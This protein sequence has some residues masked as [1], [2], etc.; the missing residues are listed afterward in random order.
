[1]SDKME[2]KSINSS[3]G[4]MTKTDVTDS[5]VKALKK[6]KAEITESV[7]KALKSQNKQITPKDITEAVKSALKSNNN[8]S[9]T[10]EEITRSVEKAL[11]NNEKPS[12]W[13]IIKFFATALL[14]IFIGF[15]C[16]L[17]YNWLFVA[18]LDV[19][20]KSITLLEDANT[21]SPNNPESFKTI[22]IPENIENNKISIGYDPDDTYNCYSPKLNVSLDYTGTIKSIYV[23]YHDNIYKDFIIQ[24]VSGPEPKT[25]NRIDSTY[26]SEITLSYTLEGGTEAQR[27]YLVI[28]DEQNTPTIFCALIERYDPLKTEETHIEFKSSEE[29]HAIV[30]GRGLDYWTRNKQSIIHEITD[31]LTLENSTGLS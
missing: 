20:I 13:P 1:M 7:V 19:N 11:S 8:K 25:I 3:K 9:I 28:T 18:P 12:M 2:Q 17:A 24:K 23:F 6:S 10:E 31:I 14:T 5:V 26:D 30:P 21:L 27:I 16:K 4:S 22:T 15:I 29:I